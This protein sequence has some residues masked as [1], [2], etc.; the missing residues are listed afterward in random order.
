MSDVKQQG[1]S[2]DDFVAYRPM[3]NYIFLPTREPW[4]ASSVNAQLPTIALL[5][6]HGE[7]VLDKKGNAVMIPANAWLDH[8]RP[9]HQMTWSPGE[10][11]LIHNRIVADGGWITKAETVC[12]NLYRPAII[13]PG[14]RRK[15]KRWVDHVKKVYPNDADHIIKWLAHRVQRPAEKINHALMLGGSQGTGKDTLL[16]PIKH[17]IGHWNFVEVSPMQ[18]LGRFNGFVKSVI[19]RVSEARDLGESNRFAAYD[20]MKTYCAAPPDVLRVDE[21]NLR[22]HSVFN[23][24]GVIITSNH[25]S[26]GIY[27]P[28]DDRRTYVAWSDLTKDDFD[29]E[30]WRDLW[31]WYADGGFT[32]VAAYLRHLDLAAFDAKAPPPKTAAFWAIVDSNRAPEEAELADA[33]ERLDNPSVLTLE[34]LIAATTDKSFEEW[35]SDRKNRRA[36]PHRLESAGYVP[37]RNPDADSGLWRIDRA[38]ASGRIETMRLVLYSRRDLSLRDQLAAVTTYRKAATARARTAAKK[39]RLFP[40]QP[41]NR[42]KGLQ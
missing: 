24:T 19:L 38:T 21:K 22:E 15:A 39:P 2:F 32:H 33:I 8:N 34:H 23:C 6:D 7:P 10:E 18:M 14:D 4:P 5:D 31:A 27:L 17:A 12:L 1:I 40:L 25:K 13:R 36:I 41:P 42:S 20:H 37:V 9:A 30:Y 26:D 16:E 35:L 11:M 3:H 28:A 29:P